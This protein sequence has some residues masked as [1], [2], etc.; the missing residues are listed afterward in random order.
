MDRRTLCCTGGY[1]P[2]I[3]TGFNVFLYT[4]SLFNA[5]ITT[6][7]SETTLSY[8]RSFLMIPPLKR[9]DSRLPRFLHV[10]D[11]SLCLKAYVHQGFC[12]AYQASPNGPVLY[13]LA[14]EMIFTSPYD[15]ILASCMLPM[16][17]IAFIAGRPSRLLCFIVVDGPSA[18]SAS[19]TRFALYLVSLST[20]SRHSG[21]TASICAFMPHQL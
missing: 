20:I 19:S 21:Q 18:Y 3:I 2:P 8:I 11:L 6:H 16:W 10:D 9:L 13:Q 1:S 17:S 14:V 12:P 7:S 15:Y 4:I 5:D